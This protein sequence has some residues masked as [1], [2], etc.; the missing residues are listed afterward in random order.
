MDI[1]NSIIRKMNNFDEHYIIYYIENGVASPIYIRYY[2]LSDILYSSLQSQC[3]NLCNGKEVPYE[4][5]AF[6]L[7]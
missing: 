4:S 5:F 6:V 3:I 7:D 1:D 2:E